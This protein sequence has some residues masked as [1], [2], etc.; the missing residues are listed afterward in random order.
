MSLSA[1]ERQALD[2]IEDELAGTAPELVKLLAGF[3]RLASG[4]EMPARERIRPA[5]RR[6]AG[7]V[8]RT[9]CGGGR[10]LLRRLG[11]QRTFLL[12][13]LA[14]AL[15]LI[16]VAL[17]VNRSAVRGGCTAS[18]RVV[19]ASQMFAGRGGLVIPPGVSA[20]R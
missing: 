10:G 7:K 9:L 5:G 3:T 19:C 8:G 1:H 14:V 17:V 16:T 6:A 12:L 2:A 20:A 13:W 15:S 4:E 18:W 11:R